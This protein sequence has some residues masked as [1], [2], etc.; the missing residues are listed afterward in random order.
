MGGFESIISTMNGGNFNWFL[1]TML[2]MHTMFIIEK[3]EEKKRKKEKK[4]NSKD[5]DSEDDSENDSD[6]EGA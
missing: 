1:H 4:N 5:D 3:Q 6:S 2:F